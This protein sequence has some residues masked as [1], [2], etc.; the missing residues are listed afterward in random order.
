MI[1]RL[2]YFDMRGRAEATRLFL[3]ATDSEFDDVRIATR[4]EWA[5]LQPTTPFGELPA[6]EHRGVRLVQSNAILRH[7]GRTLGSPPRGEPALTELDVAH[8]AIAE[9]QE[10]LWRFNWTRDYY[11]RLETYAEET[12]R[13]RLRRLERWL[14]RDRARLPQWF[15]VAFSHVDCLAFG[16]LDEIDAFFPAVLAEFD[17]LAALR[18]RVASQPGVS[19]YLRSARR[20]IVFGLG[21][22]GPKVDPRMHVPSG[23]RDTTPWTEPVDLG[24]V[25]RAQRRLT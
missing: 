24:D 3:H 18:L 9:C 10:D 25:V 21:R 4:E 17:A 14:R 8:E 1:P 19:D 6:W 5:A 7:L 11:D 20:P 23:V 22:M 12:L 15:G 13:P 16:Y 2:V